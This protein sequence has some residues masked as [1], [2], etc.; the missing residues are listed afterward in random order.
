[1]L[2]ADDGHNSSGWLQ[3]RPKAGIICR[4]MVPAHR[5]RKYEADK[6]AL[7]G[8]LALGIL[9]AERAGYILQSD[10]IFE[11]GSKY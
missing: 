3:I 1:M 10:K 11:E 7:F 5:I 8:L 2:S 9:I 4:Y 6:I